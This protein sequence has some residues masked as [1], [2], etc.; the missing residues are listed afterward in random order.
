MTQARTFVG[1]V[2]S[3]GS[4]CDVDV[5]GVAIITAFD[6]GDEDI[7][8]VVGIG[9]IAGAVCG[10]ETIG[11]CDESVVN[12]VNLSTSVHAAE[13]VSSG[14]SRNN[15]TAANVGSI[16]MSGASADLRFRFRGRGLLLRLDGTGGAAF[17]IGVMLPGAVRARAL[18]FV[19]HS[20]NAAA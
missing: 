19:S 17:L 18:F 20:K 2:S 4:G 10:V 13:I 1:E 14:Y 6:A 15:D 9:S 8:S 12:Y 7:T 11:D 16:I 3:V 5:G